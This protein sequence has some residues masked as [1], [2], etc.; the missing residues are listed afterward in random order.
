[1]SK[2]APKQPKKTPQASKLGRGLSALMSEIAVPEATKPAPKKRTVKSTAKKPAK[3]QTAT[4][5][6]GKSTPALKTE[7]KTLT[8][9][10]LSNRGVNM[11][12][13]DKIE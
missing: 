9:S 10:P 6:T 4:K 1:M 5:N 11:I 13:I 2:A 8:P 7:K 12:A 3:K